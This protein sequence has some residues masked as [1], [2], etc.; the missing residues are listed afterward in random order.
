MVFALGCAW[1][2]S[3]SEKRKQLRRTFDE[4]KEARAE[5][6]NITNRRHDG[7]L[8]PPNKITVNEWLDRWLAM[9]AE[10]LEETTIYNYGVTLDRV[11]GRLGDI[12]LQD[13]TEEH[14]EEW[15]DWA[16]AHGRVRVFGTRVLN[17]ASSGA[18]T[19]TPSY[20][21][22][23][24]ETTTGTLDPHARQYDTATGR[25]TSP[26][27]A[28]RDQST[29][30]VYADNAPTLLTDPSG[31]T[32]DDPNDRV[33]S[34][35]EA[36]GIFGDAFVDKYLPVR[37]AYRLYRAEYM[38]RQQGCDALA[39]L[40]GEA[41]DEL[42]QQIALVGVGGLTGWRRQA[43]EAETSILGAEG[44]AKSSASGG[45][46]FHGSDVKSLVDVLNKGLDATAAAAGHTDGPGGQGFGVV[47]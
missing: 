3:R 28:T 29:P 27:P 20:T 19:S 32:P 41:A 4:L 8:V 13:L 10:D 26:D 5:C 7:S 34:L 9:K 38:L 36:L 18:P 46:F 23:R 15:R 43:Y 42:A 16:L 6:A 31:M 25:F 17:T 2:W 35:G 12:R 45:L 47:V 21:G 39:D 40:Y 30:Y 24:Y 33:D 37:P 1:R 14:V 44:L 22:A 11:R